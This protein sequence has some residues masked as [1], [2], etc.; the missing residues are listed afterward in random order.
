[1]SEYYKILGQLSGI[2][3]RLKRLLTERMRRT[4][5]IRWHEEETE[6]LSRELKEILDRTRVEEAERERLREELREIP[7]PPP[8]KFFR[9]QKA[10]EYYA[11]TVFR[12]QETPVPFCEYRC[13][14]Y[15]KNPEDWPEERLGGELNF[16]EYIASSHGG[17]THVAWAKSVY[18]VQSFESEPVDEDEVI[19]SLDEI[20]WNCKWWHSPRRGGEIE[21]KH[22][23]ILKCIKR[24]LPRVK[25]PE[26]IKQISL[27]EWSKKTLPP[28]K[29]K[30]RRRRK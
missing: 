7:K 17:R 12:K 3:R 1:M 30:S 18:H 27:E 26:R 2:A 5:L 10:R 11:K 15:T 4:S 20:Q 13:W 23:K 24:T 21:Y 6:R 8:I 28:R 9:I 22:D 16:L 19:A 25:A 29:F 14:I